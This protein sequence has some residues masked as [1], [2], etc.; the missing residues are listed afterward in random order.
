MTESSVFGNIGVASKG[1]EEHASNR[2]HPHVAFW[3]YA[4]T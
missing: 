2:L 1:G 4:P 3:E